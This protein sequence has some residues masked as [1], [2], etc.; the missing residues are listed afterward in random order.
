MTGAQ[1]SFDVLTDPPFYFEV[2]A[3][4]GAVVARIR[5]HDGESDAAADI[6]SWRA[7]ECW[8]YLAHRADRAKRPE[9]YA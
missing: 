5:V 9:V 1:L 8:A 6:W 3:P 7:G 4:D 2:V